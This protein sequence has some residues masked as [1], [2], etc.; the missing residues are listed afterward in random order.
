MHIDF[1]LGSVTNVSVPLGKNNGA[2][3]EVDIQVGDKDLEVFYNGLTLNGADL[4]EALRLY[5][6]YRRLK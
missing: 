1:S 4:K 3:I 2:I 5:S 6:F